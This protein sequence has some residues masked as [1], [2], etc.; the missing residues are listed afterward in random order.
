MVQGGG[1]ICYG[2]AD[3]ALAAGW[4]DRLPALLAALRELGPV[5]VTSSPLARCRVPAEALA[6]RLGLPLS[7]DDR[8]LELDFGDWERRPWDEVPREALDFWAADP[9]GFAPPGGESGRSLVRRTRAVAECL[10]RD[11]RPWLV[12]AHGGPLRLLAPMLR[13]EPPDLLAP[14][15]PCFSLRAVVPA[16]A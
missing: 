13:G 5:A 8:L 10:R 14:A 7:L 12:V 1:G 11:R 9:L 16:P 2:R 4:Q 3:L 15:P 6:E